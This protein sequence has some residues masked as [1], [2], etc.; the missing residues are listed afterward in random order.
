MT[1]Q[2]PLE[3][4][5][6]ELQRRILSLLD[7]F[8]SL[9]AIIRASPRLHQVFRLNQKTILSTVTFRQF[10]PERV[11]SPKT[12]DLEERV[13]SSLLSLLPIRDL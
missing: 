11:R 12:D 9:Y 13:R 7:S 1:S 8:E 10:D 5:S 4:L 2:N 6:P 3:L